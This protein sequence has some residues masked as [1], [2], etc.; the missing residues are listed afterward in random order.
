MDAST[1]TAREDYDGSG[2]NEAGIPGSNPADPSTS[3]SSPTPAYGT[4]VTT[5]KQAGQTVAVGS[6]GG[7][8]YGASTVGN[9]CNLDYG[10]VQKHDYWIL[11]PERHDSALHQEI[12]SKEIGMTV[13]QV[14]TIK[15]HEPYSKYL[16]LIERHH[17]EPKH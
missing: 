4:A 16:A 17:D 8:A 7:G 12:K 1:N 10:I 3:S 6:D 13:I 11:F 5:I 9:G 14:N 2:S 15:H